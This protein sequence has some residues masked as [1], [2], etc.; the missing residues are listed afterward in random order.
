VRAPGKSGRWQIETDIEMVS[1]WRP[2]EHP[3]G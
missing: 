3:A 1:H 2:A